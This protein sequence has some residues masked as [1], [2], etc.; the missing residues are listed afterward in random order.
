MAAAPLPELGLTMIVVVLVFSVV[1]SSMEWCIC[2]F[3]SRLFPTSLIALL[4][5]VCALLAGYHVPLH[6]DQ[7]GDI[8]RLL[9]LTSDIMHPCRFLSAAIAFHVYHA[10]YGIFLLGLSRM[11]YFLPM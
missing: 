9:G 2:F 10:C 4:M 1:R 8:V 7:S 3:A 6:F 11:I 5:C